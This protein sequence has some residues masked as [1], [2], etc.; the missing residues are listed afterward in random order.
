MYACQVFN[1][2]TVSVSLRAAIQRHY[3]AEWVHTDKLFM[4]AMRN[5]H[6]GASHGAKPCHAT[7]QSACM[8]S[9]HMRT[10]FAP[11]LGQFPSRTL[12]ININTNP[13]PKFLIAFLL[14]LNGALL[15]DAV[16]TGLAACSSPRYSRCPHPTTK[17]RTVR[18]PH[19]LHMQA[20]FAKKCASLF[21]WGPSAP[22]AIFRAHV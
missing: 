9:K 11:P 4:R 10:P 19:M 1:E 6:A 14:A 7:S 5:M 21:R 20:I 2:A 15:F 12:C 16:R 17:A 13:K 3:C 18:G 8:A 22:S